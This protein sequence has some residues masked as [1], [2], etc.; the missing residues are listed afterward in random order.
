MIENGTFHHGEAHLNGPLNCGYSVY[1]QEYSRYITSN[2]CGHGTFHSSK[3][4]SNFFL[5]A[6]L[7]QNNIPERIGLFI[8]MGIVL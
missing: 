5:T 6:H 7:S 2:I 1:I 4:S 3:I 8:N